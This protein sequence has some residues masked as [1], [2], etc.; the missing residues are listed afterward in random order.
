LAVIVLLVMGKML[1]GLL[2]QPDVLV[3]E[4]GGH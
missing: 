1:L 3:S 4:R 2:L